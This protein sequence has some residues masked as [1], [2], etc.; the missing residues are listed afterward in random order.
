[1]GDAIISR[2]GQPLSF[3]TLS[4]SINFVSKT[5][6]EIVVTFTNNEQEEVNLYYDITTTPPTTEITLAS[7]ATSSNVTFDQLQPDTEYTIYAYAIVTNQLSKKITSEIVSTKI[8]T[9]PIFY[10]AATGGT[11]Q[12][13]D[14]NGKRYKSH[15]FTSDGDFVVTQVGDDIDDRNK[16][17]FLIIAGGGG[18]KDW[19]GGGG[20]GG[21]ITSVGTSGGNSSAEAKITVTAQTY[22]IVVGAGG[23]EITNGSN[24]T[25]FG[26]TAIGGGASGYAAVRAGQNG[27]SGGGG[28]RNGARGLGTATQGTNGGEGDVAF[29]GSGGGGGGAGDPGTN[30]SGD[31]PGGGGDGLANV[32][33]TGSNETRAGGGGGHGI[34]SSGQNLF[35]SGGLGGGGNAALVGQNGVINTGSG[36]GSG[37]NNSTGGS[38]G[39]GI[40]IVRYEIAPSV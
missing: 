14:S 32:I 21:Y 40:V 4:P 25:A 29:Q 27:G 34:N 23:G 11:T 31:N 20:A 2:R 5:P 8:S 30:A 1:M 7:Q 10:T 13:Y 22:G 17:D 33:R 6:N 26:Y 36:G 12:E 35:A 39:S 38:G 15:T 9:L 24:S 19:A 28:T 16:I 3:R 37:A 18:S